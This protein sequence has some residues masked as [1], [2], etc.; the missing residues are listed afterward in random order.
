MLTERGPRLTRGEP[1][2][3]R[4]GAPE[5]AVSETNDET[6][7][8]R[9]EQDQ[10]LRLQVAIS[11]ILLGYWKYAGY[12]LAAVL[13]VALVYG[14]GSSWLENRSKSEYAAISKVDFLMPKPDQLGVYGLG[15]KDDPNDAKRM[16][17]LAEGARRYSAIASTAHGSAAVYAWLRAA[18][19]YERGGKKDDRLAA[20][21]S[22]A[23]LKAGG[24]PGFTADAAYA[25]ALQDAGRTDDAL[26]Y[27]RDMSGRNKDFYAEQSLILLAT[28]QFDA[29]KADDAKK[30]IEEF[31]ARFATSANAAQVAALAARIGSGG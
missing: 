2:N 23:D 25:S 4:G 12:A 31:H 21:K 11:D 8:P 28:A 19:A 6:S 3:N 18:D 10:L 27:Y 14:L 30:T 24:L 9:Q 7:A 22:A 15:P 1:S 26:A 29:G 17:D 20:L 5:S 13:V 16:A